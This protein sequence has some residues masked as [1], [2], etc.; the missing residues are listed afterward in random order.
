MKR[1]DIHTLVARFLDGETTL[2]EERRLYAF[3]QREDMHEEMKKYQEMFRGFAAIV[4]KQADQQREA[5][6]LPLW[7]RVTSIAAACL[8]AVSLIGYTLYN[9][10]TAR[11]QEDELMV[12]HPIPQPKE[13]PKMI[14]EVKEVKEEVKA[15]GKKE[16]EKKVVEKKV[17][18]NVKADEE[19]TAEKEVE[20]SVV[21]EVEE[22]V[23]PTAIYASNETT[24]STY[25]APSRMDEF[26][27]KF[28]AYNEVEPVALSCMQT[29][30]STVAIAAYIFPD[31][32]ELDVFARLLQ[33]ACWY[34][35]AT[36]GYHLN[37]SHLQFFFELKDERKS[38]KY[39]W[40]ADRINGKILLYGTHSPIGT[41]ISSECY[42]ELR[43]ELMH[44][45]SKATYQ[46]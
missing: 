11:P 34:D 44:A 1:E 3:F 29:G 12:H 32:K 7:I 21:V 4:P 15:E 6:K 27:A 17:V 45:N 30:D 23:A 20:E 16:V 46:L 10:Y 28:A 13:E 37:F 5:K 24:D 8:L 36:P 40:I 14:A 26:I 41:T 35:D 19:A 33:C 39:L 18:V 25:Q 42:Q 43:N 9:Y 38:L 31:T 2:E 22:E